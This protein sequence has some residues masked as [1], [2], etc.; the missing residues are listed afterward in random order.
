MAKK[1]KT[2]RTTK[3]IVL[4]QVLGLS[5]GAL[6]VKYFG[7]TLPTVPPGKAA[8]RVLDYFAQMLAPPR[9]KATEGVLLRGV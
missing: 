1:A 3:P 2:K 4:V 9:Q 5:D 8:A 7:T 6:K